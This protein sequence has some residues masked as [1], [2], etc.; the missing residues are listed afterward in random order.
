MTNIYKLLMLKSVFTYSLFSRV[1]GCCCCLFVFFVMFLV[2]FLVVFFW[3]EGLF[4][5]VFVFFSIERHLLVDVIHYQRCHHYQNCYRSLRLLLSFSCG[6][7][8]RWLQALDFISIQIA[9]CSTHSMTSFLAPDSYVEIVLDKLLAVMIRS[10]A[11]S[12]LG[13]KKSHFLHIDS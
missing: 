7:I 12:I 11:E 1:C 10:L 5:F 3:G 4:C 13:L 9:L 2:F 8:T 6:L